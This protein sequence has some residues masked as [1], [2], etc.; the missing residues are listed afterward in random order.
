MTHLT[1]PP[2]PVET[3]VRCTCGWR[4]KRLDQPARCSCGD[5]QAR[6]FC[7]GLVPS[8]GCRRPWVLRPCPRCG[9]GVSL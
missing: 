8:P 5:P 4:G 2:A 3:L 7:T 6:F 9:A 1:L